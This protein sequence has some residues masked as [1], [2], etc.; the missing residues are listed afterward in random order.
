[1]HC[2][3]WQLQAIATPIVSQIGTIA[4]LSRV[5]AHL[6]KIDKSYEG[7]RHVKVWTALTQEANSKG[8]EQPDSVFAVL[9]AEAFRKRTRDLVQNSFIDALEA[10]KSQIR[11]AVGASSN[12]SNRNDYRLS[13]I[14]FYDYFERIQDN[15]SAL[16]ASDLQSVLIEEFMRT[17]LKLVIFLEKDYPLR[18]DHHQTLANDPVNRS[19]VFLAISNI[20]AGVL[21]GF[22]ARRD[23][24]F[25]GVGSDVSKNGP[26][27]AT[28]RALFAKHSSK[29]FLRGAAMIQLL[30]VSGRL[31]RLESLSS[32]ALG[33]KH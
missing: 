17:L 8:K 12:S 23:K 25:P 4:L 28:L 15:T 29:G 20:L 6:T 11:S 30:Q 7:C 16:D 18:H 32:V 31:L 13:G 9:F 5:Q 22:P 33:R 27:A 24:L 2:C 19:I 26:S 21:A 10:I 1:M 14:T 3:C